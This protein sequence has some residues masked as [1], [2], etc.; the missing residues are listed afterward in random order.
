MDEKEHQLT[1]ILK[2]MADN[3]KELAEV[4]KVLG[5]ELMETRAELWNLKRRLGMKDD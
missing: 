2:Q 1:S 4:I 3:D 5:K